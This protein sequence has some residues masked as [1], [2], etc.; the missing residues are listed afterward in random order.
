MTNRRFYN[1]DLTRLNLLR[2]V[3]WKASQGTN[4]AQV[5]REVPV[6]A[7]GQKNNRPHPTYLPKKLTGLILDLGCNTK[8]NQ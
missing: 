8:G 6:T 2:T 3:R 1:T 7:I 4:T 5:P